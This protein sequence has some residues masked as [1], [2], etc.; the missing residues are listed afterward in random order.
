MVQLPNPLLT[1]VLSNALEPGWVPTKMGGSSATEDL[2]QAHRTELWVAV[3]DE[4]CLSGVRR[5]LLSHGE[6]A[7]ASCHAPTPQ[8][9]KFHPDL[10]PA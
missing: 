4:P 6:T 9:W 1:S 5:M 7:S 10:S 3:S 8:A 2:D